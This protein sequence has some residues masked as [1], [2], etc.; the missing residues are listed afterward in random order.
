MGGGAGSGTSGNVPHL[1][2]AS[3]F[4]A[5]LTLNIHVESAKMWEPVP[6]WNWD[7]RGTVPHP[8]RNGLS[9]GG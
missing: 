8:G 4:V 3:S 6:S 7:L 2:I 9:E 1:P 5:H